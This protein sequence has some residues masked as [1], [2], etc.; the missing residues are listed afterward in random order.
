MCG[1]IEPDDYE[2]YHDLHGPDDCGLHCISRVRLVERRTRPVLRKVTI[3]RGMVFYL[4]PGPMNRSTVL[5]IL[6]SRMNRSTVTRP[7]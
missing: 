4:G 2:W 5:F 1:F 3:M 7:A 6:P